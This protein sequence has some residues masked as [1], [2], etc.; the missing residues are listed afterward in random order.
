M[1][2]L[3]FH[4]GTSYRPG[5]S[6]PQGVQASAPASAAMYP[7]SPGY[8]YPWGAPYQPAGP[9]A[10]PPANAPYAS[11]PWQAEPA[12]PSRPPEPP[13]ARRTPEEEAIERHVE[14]FRRLLQRSPQLRTFLDKVSVDQLGT[15]LE[16][17]Q[18]QQVFSS[19]PLDQ[20]PAMLKNP[21][22]VQ[23]LIMQTAADS[24]LGQ[25]VARMPRPVK[26]LISMLTPKS[27]RPTLQS[28]FEQASR[29][30]A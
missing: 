10:Y 20:L 11:T 28:F 27:L 2:A 26:G 29:N 25:T 19:V 24:T 9:G 30:G 1:Q 3:T 5:Y 4:P 22:W 18:L 14:S 12:T 15:A 21:D 16:S 7:Q 8:A 17:P 23:N 6:S 13:P